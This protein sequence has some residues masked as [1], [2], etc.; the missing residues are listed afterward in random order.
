[1]FQASVEGSEASGSKSHFVAA[2][3]FVNM[4]LVVS[5]VPQASFW[6]AAFGQFAGVVILEV[7]SLVEES[8]LYIRKVRGHC[9]LGQV[10]WPPRYPLAHLGLAPVGPCLDAQSPAVC[11]HYRSHHQDY[12]NYCQYVVV[13]HDGGCTRR[14]TS[15]REGVFI[16]GSIASLPFPVAS[17]GISVRVG[18]CP[19]QPPLWRPGPIKLN[20]NTDCQ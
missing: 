7:M 3:D 12:G 15:H 1:M 14:G 6:S 19:P 9:G 8:L 10:V 17:C 20:S 4:V 2:R 18:Q 11:Q 13:Q 5:G 16:G